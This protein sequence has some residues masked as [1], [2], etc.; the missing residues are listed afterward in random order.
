M[1]TQFKDK[2]YLVT[3]GSRGIGEKITLG[4]LNLGANGLEMAV[5][6]WVDESESAWV[7][8][9]S[10]VNILLLQALNEQGIVIPSAQ[11]EVRLVGMP[12]NA[13]LSVSAPS[14][15]RNPDPNL[16]P[17]ASR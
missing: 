9:K 3:G 10:E 15:A 8:V 2:T 7:S 1:D 4:L 17:S 6:F 13:A 11:H 5:V 12:A 16:S 14:S